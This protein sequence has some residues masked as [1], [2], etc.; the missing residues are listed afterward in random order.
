MVRKEIYG[1]RRAVESAYDGICTV[2][3]YR[4]ARD[5]DSGITRQCEIKTAENIPC[6]LSFELNYPARQTGDVSEISQRAKLFVA[7]D[8]DIRNGSKIIVEQHGKTFEYAFSGETAVYPTHREIRI[9][10]FIKWA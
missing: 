9:S 2:I 7:P 4:S 6:K 1:V 8:T 5:E 10:P 3:E